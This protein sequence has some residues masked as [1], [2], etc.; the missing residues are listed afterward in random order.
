M[1]R[2]DSKK[3]FLYSTGFASL[4]L[5][6][7]PAP[8]GDGAG[9]A[10]RTQRSTGSERLSAAEW[11]QYIS[12]QSYIH[13][14]MKPDQRVRLN[15]ADPKQYAFAMARLKANGKTE[16][17]SP[18][19]FEKI[20]ER[21]K[22]QIAAGLKPGMLGE[23]IQA[24]SSIT[25]AEQHRIEGASFGVIG[26]QSGTNAVANNLDAVASSTYPGG[27]YYSW[28]DVSITTTAGQ[29]IAPFNYQEEFEPPADAELGARLIA[30]TEGDPS[31]GLIKRY[32][33]SS[34][35]YEDSAEAFNDSYTYTEVGQR[36]QFGTAN[37]PLLSLTQIS[38]P[39]DAPTSMDGLTHICLQRH[40]AD[41]DY[42][43]G[44]M[45]SVKIPMAGSVQL[46]DPFV[47]DAVQINQIADKLAAGQATP[48]EGAM[49]L[50]L[51]NVGGGC[52][53]VGNA[54]RPKMEQFWRNTTVSPDGKKLV[55]NLTDANNAEFDNSCVQYQ[56]RAV[57]TLAIKAPVVNPAN[58]DQSEIE[59]TVTSDENF[60]RPEGD[61]N[62][63]KLTNS[64]IAA[65]TKVQMARGKA[66][67]IES[68]KAG[69]D[70][71]SPFDR[72]DQALTIMDTSVGVETLPMVRI[73]DG[74]GRT[75]LMTETHP[76][77]TP[78]RGMVQAK[79]L[80]VGDQVMTNDGVTKLTEV[81][82]EAYAGKVYNLKVGSET[83]MAKLVD[84][85]TV[86]YANGFVVGD[87]Q[88]QNRHEELRQLPTAGMAEQW[89][90]DYELSAK[91][92]K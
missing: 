62:P 32:Q 25:R 38:A 6:C 8:S 28:V 5:A 58:N 27:A 53:V 2:G 41:C 3:L 83:E 7:A 4:L 60:P 49:S 20:E 68:L 39:V 26:A 66:L 61:L 24:N 46:Q 85:Q 92:K 17:N 73:R 23:S 81:S 63:I 10:T 72:D 80:Q 48:Y 57:L 11:S 13:S 31:V 16:K 35:K 67:P 55:W 40:W 15:M 37:I 84:D 56:N 50:V 65:G 90:R 42:L 14:M 33:I 70:V 43:A 29:E 36:Q 54:L 78:D 59:F 34:F 77:S 86:F 30:P 18:Y 88:I 12:N 52:D 9:E 22:Q 51:A 69:Q 75:L 44:P 21:R 74:E 19:L 1:S 82:R 71:A 64:C 91:S 47:F 89:R 76:I 87:G 79:A 45:H